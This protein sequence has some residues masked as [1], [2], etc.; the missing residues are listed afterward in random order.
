MSLI[1]TIASLG[2]RVVLAYIL[3]STILGTNGIWM[4]VPIGWF[5]ADTIG[6]VYYFLSSKKTQQ[7]Y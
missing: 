4:S 6:I 7:S 1:L 2:T 5:L 3:S